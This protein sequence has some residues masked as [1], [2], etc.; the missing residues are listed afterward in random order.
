MGLSVEQVKRAAGVRERL[1]ACAARLLTTMGVH[2]LTLDAVARDADVSKGGLLHHFSSKSDLLQTLMEDAYTKFASGIDALTVAD[3]EKYGRYTRA[4]IRVSL[5]TDV[6]HGQA[7]IIMA[8]LLDPTLRADW[9][10]KVESLLQKDLTER[11][12]VLAKILRLAADGLWLSEAFAIHK[13]SSSEREELETR[14]IALTRPSTR[15]NVGS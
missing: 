3:P 2:G 11:D 9:L 8:L 4:Y 7:S 13:I 6:V 15:R 1:L 10:A 12:P 5:E 14:L